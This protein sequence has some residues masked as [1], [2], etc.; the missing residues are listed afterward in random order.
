MD[1]RRGGVA[2]PDGYIFEL[3]GGELC[4][5]FANTVDSRPTEEPRELLLAYSD[6]ISWS[7]QAGTLTEGEAR[8]L[9]RKAA[10]HPSQAAAVL[11][12]ARRLRETLFQ[13]FSA[14]AEGHEPDHALL[15]ELNDSLP[16]ALV[17]LRVA[18]SA[19][20]FA[21][22]WSQGGEL[23]RML[24]PV[25]NSAGELLISDNLERV[26]EC[27]ADDCAWLF[28]DQSRNRS[29]R[30]CDMTVCGNRDKVQR[31]RARQ[32]RARRRTNS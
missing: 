22:D 15:G 26:R 5:D 29:R 17:H 4:L 13:L 6:L 11:R 2:T 21:W 20:G 24:W 18:R 25:L 14:V 28:L 8:G 3:S 9:T 12:R 1:V 32:R 19:S 30:W 16:Q 31:H 27:A 10:R 7:K 23:D